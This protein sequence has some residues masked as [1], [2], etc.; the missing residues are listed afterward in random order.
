[1]SA[2]LSKITKVWKLS[3]AYILDLTRFGGYLIS[4]QKGDPLCHQPVPLT[5]PS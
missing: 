5:Q 4:N 2:F 3:I 1:M